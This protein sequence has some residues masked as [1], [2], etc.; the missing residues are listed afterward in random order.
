MSPENEAAGL[1]QEKQD[2]RKHQTNVDFY[3]RQWGVERDL[4]PHRPG[5]RTKIHLSRRT[6]LANFSTAFNAK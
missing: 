5:N 3:E 1:D 6:G 2:Q 4:R